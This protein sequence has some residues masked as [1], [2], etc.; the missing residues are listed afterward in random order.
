MDDLIVALCAERPLRARDLAR[1]L[2][3]SARHLR[4]AYLSRLVQAGRPQLSNSPN[5]SSV[6]Y[7][8]VD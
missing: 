6:S 4:D 2:S 5:D 8:S 3:H 1:V 7:K